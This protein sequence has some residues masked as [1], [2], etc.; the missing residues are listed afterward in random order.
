LPHEL[1]TKSRLKI[2]LDFEVCSVEGT[3]GLDN[4]N[5]DDIGHRQLQRW[6]R[7][8]SVYTRVPR[9]TQPSILPRSVNRGPACIGRGKAG[10]FT[11]AGWQGKVCV[12]PYGKWHPVAV[13]Y[14]TSAILALPLPLRLWRILSY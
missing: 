10:A 12:I 7:L 2:D 3:L 6:A 14:C 13:R 5:Y 1:S 11:C 8:F 9:P 4:M